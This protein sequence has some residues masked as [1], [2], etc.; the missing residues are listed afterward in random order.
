[1]S[2]SSWSMLVMVGLMT[3]SGRSVPVSCTLGRRYDGSAAPRSSAD[4]DPVRPALPPPGVGTDP[5]EDDGRGSHDRIDHPHPPAR[6]PDRVTTATPVPPVAMR[7]LRARGA[8]APPPPGRAA[9]GGRRVGGPGPAGG[10]AAAPWPGCD[11]PL[12]WS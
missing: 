5:P 2:R 4:V 11:R 3:T 9:A 7:P 8:P 6:R 10:D 1:M 12:A